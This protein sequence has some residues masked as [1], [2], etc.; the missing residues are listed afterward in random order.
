MSAIKAKMRGRVRKFGDNIDTDVITPAATLQLP[1][2][3][4]REHA[5]EPI[6]KD[7]YKTVKDGDIIVAG[8]NFGC[9]SSREFATEVIKALGINFIVCESIARIYFRNC[10]ALG[11]YPIVSK[12]IGGIFNEGDEIE[13][14]TKIG[15]I[16]NLKTGATASFEPLSAGAQD[17]LTAGGILQLLKQKTQK[18]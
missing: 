13:I 4:I 11:L 7:F 3:E 9:G 12:G 5:F 14:D 10:I 16:K 8:K 18:D 6:I 15:E 1:M 2:E 17:I